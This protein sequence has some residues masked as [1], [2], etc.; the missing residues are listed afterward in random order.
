MSAKRANVVDDRARTIEAKYRE[1]VSRYSYSAIDMVD[2]G[3]NPRRRP[4]GREAG[5]AISCARWK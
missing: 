4:N 1:P 5:G 3:L 2:F